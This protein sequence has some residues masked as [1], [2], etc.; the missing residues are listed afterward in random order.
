MDDVA[1]NAFTTD[2]TLLDYQRVLGLEFTSHLAS[3]EPRQHWVDAGAGRAQAIRDY[4]ESP[5]FPKKARTTAVAVVR[6]EDHGIEEAEARFRTFRYLAGAPIEDIAPR[7]IGAAHLITDVY[8]PLQYSPAVDR[9]IERYGRLLAPGGRLWT[10]VPGVTTIRQDDR[11][12]GWGEWLSAV[13]GLRAEKLPA[14]GSSALEIVLVRTRATMRVPA[15]ALI[16]SVSGPPP[17]RE[18]ALRPA[19]TRRRRRR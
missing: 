16:R 5:L 11:E 17:L 1:R 19:A 12:V 2:R 6:P 4:L 14:P 18:F 15:V 9:V 3:L 8:G 10:V 7:R 13:T